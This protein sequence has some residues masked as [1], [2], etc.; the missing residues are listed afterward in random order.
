MVVKAW[1]KILF[2][3]L[4]SLMLVFT[5][6]GY[7][8]YPDNLSI[9]GAGSYKPYEGIYITNIESVAASSASSTAC[10]YLEHTTTADATVRRTSRWNSGS[11][12]YKITV[13][14]NTKFKYSYVGI[15]YDA[16][17]SEHSGNAY[18]GNGLNIITKDNQND[19]SATFNSSD[20]IEP[21]A[22]LVFYATYNISTSLSR[23][24]DYKTLVHPNI[25]KIE[26]AIK[27]ND[28]QL[29]AKHIDNSLIKSACASN[30]ESTIVPFAS[31][32]TLVVTSPPK[33]RSFVS[34]AIP[35][36]SPFAL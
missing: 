18:I 27:E 13:Q 28:F 7:A 8:S 15:S 5:S 25:N 16:S 11:V 26:Q 23:N 1:V 17:D 19:S 4:L 24:I 14:N 6:I 10:S 29:L 35:T 22:T 30:E 2:G 12:T 34:I 33:P 9:T 21:G 20:Y 31:K 32:P 36:N 3:I